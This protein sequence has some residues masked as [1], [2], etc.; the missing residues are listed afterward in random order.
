[1]NME[2]KEKKGNYRDGKA[3]GALTVVVTDN[4]GHEWGRLYAATKDFST[5]SVGFYA[6]G[7]LA[8]PA[9]PEAKYQ[10]GLTFT[11]AHSKPE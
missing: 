5:G 7:K 8:N 4:E 9:N 2:K 10:A 11:L 3:P 1:M 6:T